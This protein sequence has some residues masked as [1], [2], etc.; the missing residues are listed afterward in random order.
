MMFSG[1]NIT[2]LIQAEFMKNRPKGQKVT[3][4]TEA[5]TIVCFPILQN[6]SYLGN[7]NHKTI[8]FNGNCLKNTIITYR[9]VSKTS[10]LGGLPK[11]D[12]V[13]RFSSLLDS[14][15]SRE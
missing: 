15:S 1:K 5:K 12:A 2:K 7:R 3:E 4:P 13:I 9:I 6:V 11:L 14:R 8:S 10:Q